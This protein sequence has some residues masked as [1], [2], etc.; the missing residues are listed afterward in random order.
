MPLEQIILSKVAEKVNSN[1]PLHISEFLAW[2]AMLFRNLGVVSEKGNVASAELVVGEMC[3]RGQAQSQQ[4]APHT[5]TGHAERVLIHQLLIR[6][7]VISRG[8]PLE[9][10]EEI[11]SR[12][13][14]QSQIRSL[15]IFTERYPCDRQYHRE[16]SCYALFDSLN[17]S[18]AEGTL[19]VYYYTKVNVMDNEIHKEALLGILYEIKNSNDLRFDENL[20]EL[21]ARLTAF[22]RHT[23]SSRDIR[24]M[25]DPPM[26][27]LRARPTS[28]HGIPRANLVEQNR[29][30]SWDND[31]HG[32]GDNM[33]RENRRQGPE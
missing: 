20:Q 4:G 14:V 16:N 19:N 33:R 1:E 9:N 5:A 15:S 32:E 30:G 27:A 31:S 24:E 29:G 6:A 7:K 13:N 21:H 11:L 25:P 23:L 17:D 28:A 18:L 3:Y 2:N 12:A 26:F 8:E 10:L 22:E